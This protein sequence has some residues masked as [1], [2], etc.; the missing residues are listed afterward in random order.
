MNKK[1]ITHEKP[2]YDAARDFI[3]QRGVRGWNMDDLADRAGIT[4]R[5][6]YR[7]INTKEEL[8][9]NIV[10]GFI[11]DVQTRIQEIITGEK[12][13]FAA[14]ELLVNEFPLLVRQFASGVMRE[15]FLE[16]PSVE[17]EVIARRSELTSGLVGFFQEGIDRGY[18]RKEYP[19]DFILQLLQ[20]Q[21]I[22]FTRTSTDGKDF[23]ARVNLAFRAVLHG[24][25]GNDDTITKNGG[26]S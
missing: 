6:L 24:V 1:S 14:L 21:V 15:V 5:T 10:I 9:R 3:F 25:R 7:I 17:E 19:A 13:Y 2:V 18:L 16:Y 20:A 11:R 23:S 4:K 12:D 26:R 22:Y 8:V